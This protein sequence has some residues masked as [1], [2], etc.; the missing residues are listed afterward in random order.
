MQL[1]LNKRNAVHESL[2]ALSSLYCFLDTSGFA[3]IQLLCKP[4]LCNGK[5]RPGHIALFVLRG[6]HS[7]AAVPY[8]DTPSLSNFLC[9]FLGT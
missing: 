8:K 5:L 4:V 2:H 3:G 1:G 6:C 9:L 7:V